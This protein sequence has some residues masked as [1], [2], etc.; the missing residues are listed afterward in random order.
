EKVINSY[1]H[2]DYLAVSGALMNLMTNEL[3]SYYLDFAK[4][5][6]YIEKKDDPRRRQV[7]SVIYTA[8]DTLCKLW[9]P[10]LVFTMEEVWNEFGS[11]EAESVHYTHFPTINHYPNAATI[12]EQFNQLNTIRSEALKALEVARAD[13]IIGKPLEAKLVINCTN[14]D[15]ELMESLTCGKVAQFLIVSE[16]EFKDAAERSVVVEKAEGMVC[17][18][19][20]NISKEHAEDGLCVRCQKVIKA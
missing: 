15:K 16:V 3:S 12:K 18:R 8:V 13:K 7:Q 9:A 5:I 14:E 11:T 1:M 10:S 20:W 17:P 6:L 19:C 4:D 2:Y